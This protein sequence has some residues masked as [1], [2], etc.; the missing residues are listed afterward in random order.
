M[1]I[2]GARKCFTYFPSSIHY[3]NFT[4]IF[5]LYLSK[6]LFHKHKSKSTAWIIL[7]IFTF[8]RE[9]SI[10][11]KSRER[12]AAIVLVAET[13]I[14]SV[15]VTATIDQSADS[16]GKQRTIARMRR[17]RFW[18][19]S[20]GKVSFVGRST[21]QWVSNILISF[22]FNIFTQFIELYDDPCFECINT[23]VYMMYEHI[24]YVYVRVATSII[25]E[26]TKF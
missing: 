23:Y 18:P 24:L 22:C 4:M 8:Q 21:I 5:L 11:V 2:F 14:D 19:Y 6:L 1:N 3:H 25:L 9:R 16:I 15:R 17:R 7:F 26:I 10:I 12:D 13:R 20:L